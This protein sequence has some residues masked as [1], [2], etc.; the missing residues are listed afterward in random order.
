MVNCQYRVGGVKLDQ[1]S[2]LSKRDD[3]YA[4]LFQ[5]VFHSNDLQFAG[6]LAIVLSNTTA[7]T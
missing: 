3:E 6:R 7:F 2:M 4:C 1:R 5:G